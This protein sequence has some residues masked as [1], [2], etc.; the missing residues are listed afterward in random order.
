MVTLH[1]GAKCVNDLPLLP[2]RNI[3]CCVCH[4]T[5]MTLP[6]KQDKSYIWT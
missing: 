5:D 6:A 3:V 4:W 2:S 1:K